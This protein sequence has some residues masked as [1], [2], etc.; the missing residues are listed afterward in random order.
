MYVIWFDGKNYTAPFSYLPYFWKLR[1]KFYAYSYTI[2]S[3]TFVF[4]ILC[5]F[6]ILYLYYNI[7]MLYFS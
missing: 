2:F 3:Y 6:L 1:A 7:F 4:P 5:H